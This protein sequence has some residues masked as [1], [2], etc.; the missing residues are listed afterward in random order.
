MKERQR[1]YRE[2]L[3]EQIRLKKQQ[4]QIQ[5][6]ANKFK[7][8]QTTNDSTTPKETRSCKNNSEWQINQDRS[9]HSKQESMNT[10]KSNNY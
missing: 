9:F 2:E 10:I 8:A 5:K 1:K 4:E 6:E 7:R 3:D